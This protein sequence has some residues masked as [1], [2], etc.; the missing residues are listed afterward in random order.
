M[1]HPT[2][3]SDS[4]FYDQKFARGV[5]PRRQ[6]PPPQPPPPPP[7]L[8]TQITCRNCQAPAHIQEH[9]TKTVYK[10]SICKTLLATMQP[11]AEVTNP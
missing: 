6:S 10:C 8:S 11:A 1:R 9:P 4:P 5:T 2:T 7:K 3:H